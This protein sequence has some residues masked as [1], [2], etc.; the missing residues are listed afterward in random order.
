MPTNLNIGAY[1]KMIEDQVV[2][3]DGMCKNLAGVN[4]VE[5]VMFHLAGSVNGLAIQ[6]SLAEDSM[7]IDHYTDCIALMTVIGAE[8]GRDEQPDPVK[9]DSIFEQFQ[10]LFQTV[11]ML[12]FD[13]TYCEVWALLLGLGEMLGLTMEQVERLFNE[14][15]GGGAA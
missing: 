12:Q 9:K 15:Y 11:G 2:S 10:H 4:R 3:E 6:W 14:W 13:D 1:A 8:L 7:L 5:L